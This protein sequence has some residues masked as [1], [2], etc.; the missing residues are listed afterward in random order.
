M[1]DE[2]IQIVLD[3]TRGEMEKAIKSLRIDLSKVRTGRA[4]PA[5]L[6]GLHPHGD[7][8]PVSGANHL[9]L[10]TGREEGQQRLAE[11]CQTAR[12]HEPR[13][14]ATAHRAVRVRRAG[15]R[16]G[17]CRRRRVRIRRPVPLGK[18]S[19]LVE[20]RVCTR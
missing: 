17:R 3:E 18:S 11:G 8:D 6:D 14:A 4:N 2:D 15:R 19:L 5:L 9:G 12:H 7:R 10:R 20:L 16:V 13:A 1:A